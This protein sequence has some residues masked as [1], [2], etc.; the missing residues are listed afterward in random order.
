MR[1]DDRFFT[2]DEGRQFLDRF[3]QLLQ[4]HRGSSLSSRLPTA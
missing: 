1:F 3:V 2:P 4:I